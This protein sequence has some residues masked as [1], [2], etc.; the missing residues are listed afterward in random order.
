MNII[1]ILNNAKVDKIIAGGSNGSII[2]IDLVKE[3]NKYVIY[4]YCAWRVS[5]NNKV[6]TG[7][8][9]KES[10]FVNKLKELQED[11]IIEVTSNVLGDFNLLFKSGKKLD[12]FCD[13]TS[14]IEESSMEENWSLCDILNNNCYNFT[15]HFI[16]LQ[17][18]YDQDALE[19]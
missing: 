2:L 17:E 7:W 15:N 11:I 3:C 16:L 10:I 5:F 6:L 18:P 8:N 12:V 14:N 4:I 19:I 1:N 9:D 13:I